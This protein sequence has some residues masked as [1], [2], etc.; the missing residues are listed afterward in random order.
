MF[1]VHLPELRRRK[2]YNFVSEKALLYK[3]KALD[4]IFNKKR[5]H[6]EWSQYHVFSL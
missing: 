5:K 1:I 6:F 2:T 3:K 4:F